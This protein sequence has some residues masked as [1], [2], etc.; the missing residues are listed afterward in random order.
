MKAE[1]ELDDSSFHIVLCSI[2]SILSYLGRN[3]MFYMDI[4]IIIVSSKS[5]G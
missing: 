4:S 2:H 5:K 1:D 3:L